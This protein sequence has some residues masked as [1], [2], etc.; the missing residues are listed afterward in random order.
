MSL[1]DSE[2]CFKCSSFSWIMSIN[3]SGIWAAEAPTWLTGAFAT[4]QNPQTLIL[5]IIYPTVIVP[6]QYQSFGGI[7]ATVVF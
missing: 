5:G 3:R 6:H 7:A 4:G 1:V 2:A